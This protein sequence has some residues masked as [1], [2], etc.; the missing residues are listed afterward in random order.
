[1]EIDES[2]F[3]MIRETLLSGVTEAGRISTQLVVREPSECVNLGTKGAE[4]E[5]FLLIRLVS[6][7]HVDFTELSL[8]TQEL[9]I[10]L[11]KDLISL[12]LD[13]SRLLNLPF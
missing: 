11:F 5:M 10:F 6:V 1:M 9:V 13:S 2:L 7:C 8:L 3:W 12:S 4:I